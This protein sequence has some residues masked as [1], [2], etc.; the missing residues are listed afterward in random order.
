[1]ELDFAL[2]ADAAEVS[3]G[4]LY[5]IGGA[6]DRYFAQTY[7]TPARLAIVIAVLVPWNQCNEKQP[8]SVSIVDADGTNVVPDITAQVEVGRPPGLTAGADQRAMLAINTMFPLN[9][10]GRYEVRI[11][12]GADGAEKKIAFDAVLGTKAQR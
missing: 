3:G 7:P 12:P 6:W 5:V 1:M 10:P 4:K 9:K 8:I 11:R 2:I